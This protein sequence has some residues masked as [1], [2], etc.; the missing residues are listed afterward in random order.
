LVGTTWNE[1][2]NG[3]RTVVDLKLNREWR[4][5]QR[6][7]VTA[8]AE[9]FNLFNHVQRYDR[10]RFSGTDAAPVVVNA[11]SVASSG[12]EVQLGARFAF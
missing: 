3:I 4:F 11:A 9:I 6:Y 7:S 12:R 10:R 2:W 5:A 1:F 8:S